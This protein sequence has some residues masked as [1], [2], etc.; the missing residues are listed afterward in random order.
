MFIKVFIDSNVSYLIGLDEQ[1][2]VYLV[3]WQL[4]KTA[5]SDTAGNRIYPYLFHATYTLMCTYIAQK[6]LWEFS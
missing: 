2:D 6:C 4:A 1:V 5:P 3:C